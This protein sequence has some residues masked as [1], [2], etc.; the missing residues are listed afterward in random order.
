MLAEGHI[1]SARP[2]YARAAALG[3]AA[4]ATALGKTYDPLFLANMHASGMRADPALAEAWYK[5]GVA[6]GD[7]RAASR[8]SSLLAMQKD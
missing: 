5:R 3:D 4:A 2:L 7:P 6:L 8:L 1:A